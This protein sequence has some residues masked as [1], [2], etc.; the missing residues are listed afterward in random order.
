MHNDAGDKG[1]CDE[2][3]ERSVV[4]IIS[5]KDFKINDF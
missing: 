3:F 4:Q 5:D 2:E 1:A